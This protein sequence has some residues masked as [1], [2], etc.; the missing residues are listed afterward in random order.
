MPKSPPRISP[1]TSDQYHQYYE[2]YISKVGKNVLQ[3]LDDQ[4]DEMKE[5]LG[6]LKEGQDNCLHEPY[7]WTLKQV[8]GHMIDCERAFSSR[9][10]RIAVGDQTPIPGI[11][12]NCYVE[13]LDYDAVSMKSLLKE[14]R[15]LR[16]SNVLMVNRLEPESLDNV[17]VASD[18]PVSAKANLFIL[19]G[20]VTYHLEIIRSRLGLSP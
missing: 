5:V 7:T 12:Q 4:P 2:N 1:P 20:H 8:V 19:V 11:D 6:K 16:K 17:G 3:E 9:I 15:Q 18:Y 14:F 10:F 13:S